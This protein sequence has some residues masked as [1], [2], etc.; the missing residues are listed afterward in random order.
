M[1]RQLLILGVVLVLACTIFWTGCTKDQSTAPQQQA[2]DP[3]VDTPARAMQH[4]KAAYGQRD[5]DDYSDILH[6]DF[7]FFFQEH[8]ITNL[9]L[10]SDHLERTD[11]IGVSTNMF[12]GD[13]IANPGGAVD[14]A[15]AISAIEFHLLEQ[16]GD[17]GPSDHADYP[18]AQR[19]LFHIEFTITRPG[20]RTITITGQQVFYVAD[21]GAIQPDGSVLPDFRVVGQVDMSDSHKSAGKGTEE[22]TWG[23]LKS[24]YR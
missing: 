17:W 10:L 20:A 14:P 22:V 19:A 4:F 9:G 18:S 12:S 23:E 2:Q 5:I 13:P 11:E 16:V 15:P 6:G 8:D 7:K 21:R 1:Q 24:W 3:P